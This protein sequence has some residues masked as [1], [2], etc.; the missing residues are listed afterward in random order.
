[1]FPGLLLASLYAVYV[2]VL[3]FF[4][5]EYGPP[6]S[7]EE[8]SETSVGEVVIML[9][10]MAIPPILLIVGVLGSIFAGWA[11]P[12]EAAAIGAFITL[13]LVIV[14]RK[15]SWRML[16]EAVSATARTTSMVLFVIVG[17]V[18][19]TGVFIAIDGQEIVTSFLAGTGLGRWGLFVLMMAIVFVLGMFIDWLGIVL[20]C[21]PIF[22]PIAKELGFEPLWFVTM[23]AVVLQ[24]S[25]LTPPF[26]YALFYLEGVAPPGVTIGHIYRGIVPF[27]I[28]ILV[29]ALL[30]ILFPPI[31]TWLPTTL[32]GK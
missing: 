3:T 23:I 30:C 12:T 14:Y 18:G 32:F 22:L 7:E 10:K 24:T 28:L 16:Q 19:F 8:R 17:A 1:M 4:K 21:L 25:F 13:V 2:A 29:G 27:V 11:T 20:I 31:I 15:F 5:P 26:G 9:L 6:V